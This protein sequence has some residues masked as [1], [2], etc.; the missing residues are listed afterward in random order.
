MTQPDGHTGQSPGSLKSNVEA[1]PAPGSRSPAVC[2]GP[3]QPSGSV[4][5]FAFGA[6]H[7]FVATGHVAAHAG[8][9]AFHYGYAP[10]TP[11]ASHRSP[12]VRSESGAVA[13]KSGDREP[14]SLSELERQRFHTLYREH[15][16]F[17]FRNLRRLGV[18]SASLD[19]ALQDVYLVVLRRISDLQHDAHLKAWLF[20]IIF[21]VAGNHRRSARRRGNPEAYSDVHVPSAQPGPFDLAARA[22]AREFL[23]GFLA[24]LDDNRRAVFIMAE[25][26][27]LTVPE[28]SRALNANVNTVYSWLRAGRIAFSKKL[29]TI[30]QSSESE[31]G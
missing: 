22:Q 8:V 7:G 6:V 30:H 12:H 11:P 27:Q 25:L 3:S 10:L 20:A 5:R 28:I 13:L 1:R 2:Q 14:L 31:H 4:H 24:T 17:V 29:Q 21:R 23:H 16:D 26:E 9:S 15:F 18:A 19:D